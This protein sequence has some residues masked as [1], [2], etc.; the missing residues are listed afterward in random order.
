M[1]SQVCDHLGDV[2]T[3]WRTE[4]LELTAQNRLLEAILSQLKA[5]RS[6]IDAGLV[7]TEAEYSQ[8]LSRMS[9]LDDL[10]SHSQTILSDLDAKQ[11][12]RLASMDNMIAAANR[13]YRRHIRH[14]RLLRH[15]RRHDHRLTF[16][17][18]R[19]HLYCSKLSLKLTV[20]KNK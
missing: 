15:R 1:L 14:L 13:R 12:Q 19:G 5:R 18:F 11:N 9:Q 3:E 10:L 7:Q 6:Q 2:V 4:Q 17:R 20:M 8:L 16:H